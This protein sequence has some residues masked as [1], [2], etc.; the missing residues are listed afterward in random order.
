MACFV[1]KSPPG[2]THVL[3][4]SWHPSTLPSDP[5]WS[6]CNDNLVTPR[7]V[8]SSVGAGRLLLSS[9]QLSGSSHAPLRL[10]GPPEASGAWPPRDPGQFPHAPD[11]VE[12]GEA[13]PDA[14]LPQ[15]QPST[16]PSTWIPESTG[17]FVIFLPCHQPCLEG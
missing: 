8:E 17:E 13:R 7:P 5:W 9:V 16:F 15:T 2:P 12:C 14:L 10:R 6:R 3:C 1:Q 4:P 11:D